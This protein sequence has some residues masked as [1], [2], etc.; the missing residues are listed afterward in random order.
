MPP[1]DTDVKLRRMYL[2]KRYKSSFTGA[3]SFHQS[4]PESLS[5]VKYSQVLKALQHVKAYAQNRPAP[6]RFKRRKVVV[7]G[8]DAQWVIDL[9]S[10]P[11][12]AAY[13]NSNKYIFMC[14]DAFSKYLWAIPMKLK[15]SEAAL[16]VFKDILRKSGRQPQ[17][18]Q[19]DRGT[20]FK[21]VFKRYCDSIGIQ[22]F[23]VESE[24]KACI[25]ERVN[26]TILERIWR[27]MQHKG[28]FT[29]YKVLP[30]MVRNYNATVHHSTKFAPKDV[31]DLNSMEVWLNLYGKY[32]LK[33]VDKPKFSIGDKVL[34]SIYK[35][36]F[37]EKGYDKKFHDQV[38]TVERISDTNPRMYYLKSD[39]GETLGGGFYSRELSKIYI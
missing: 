8:I 28:T 5:D 20:E 27:Y 18:I 36:K 10:L 7:H 11:R 12:L 15:S 2:N 1:V 4:L 21:S 6:R 32:E 37:V 26:R 33:A 39:D 13:N 24:L 38:Y 9:V 3:Q 34:I 25:V 29:W 30:D 23:H 17:K 19:A 14:I 16:K 35:N 22:I 31:N